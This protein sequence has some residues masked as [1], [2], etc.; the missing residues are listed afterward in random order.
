MFQL[1]KVIREKLGNEIRE[2][3]LTDEL[4]LLE[5]KI[6]DLALL[7][8]DIFMQCREQV[9]ELRANEVKSMTYALLK[10]ANLLQEIEDNKSIPEGAIIIDKSTEKR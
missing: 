8:F 1:K 4:L 3:G 10:K 7:A 9:Y 5:S 2:H 6:D